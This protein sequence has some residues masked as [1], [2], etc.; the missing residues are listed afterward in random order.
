M[1]VKA[2][3]EGTTENSWESVLAGPPESISFM[4]TST[5]LPLWSFVA[6]QKRAKL[7]T[8]SEV[9]ATPNTSTPLWFTMLKW[10]AFLLPPPLF[11][12]LP[13]LHC[14]SIFF[15]SIHVY[16]MLDN[17]AD[18]QLRLLESCLRT[19]TQTKGAG[20]GSS[21]SWK[22]QNIRSIE[23]KRKQYNW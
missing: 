6:G 16:I 23:V 7:S 18:G 15:G 22:L 4:W 9:V 5:V 13:H 14:F 8:S 11:G 19:P 12:A 10:L 21:L 3:H 17:Y 20:Y 2:A 1:A